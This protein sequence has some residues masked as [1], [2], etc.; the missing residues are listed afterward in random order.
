MTV[1]LIPSWHP[2]TAR[3]LSVEGCQD[4]QTFS[5]HDAKGTSRP[6]PACGECTVMPAQPR[7]NS[8]INSKRSA[9]PFCDCLAYV[10]RSLEFLIWQILDSLANFLVSSMLLN[11]AHK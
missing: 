2:S 1:T 5:Y 9:V 7:A 8:G 3:G 6:V 10:R 4:R 11:M